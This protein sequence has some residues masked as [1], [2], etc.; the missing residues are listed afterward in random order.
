M[1]DHV[2]IL[3]VVLLLF[4]SIDP[5]LGLAPA[6]WSSWSS[7]VRCDVLRLSVVRT[8][9]LTTVR[10]DTSQAANDTGTSMICTSIVLLH[11]TKVIPSIQTCGLYVSMTERVLQYSIVLRYD[12]SV[13]NSSYGK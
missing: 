3:G 8:R 5:G 2:G 6:V 1:G 10:I 7:I 12:G 4:A 9:M 11:G 13:W